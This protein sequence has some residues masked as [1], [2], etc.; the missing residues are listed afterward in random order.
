MQILTVS[1]PA[2]MR[3]A[4]KERALA[5]RRSV[6]E[7]TREAL[8]GALSRAE[9]GEPIQSATAHP[10]LSPL[11]VPHPSALSHCSHVVQ[12]YEGEQFL[13]ENVSEFLASGL[14]KGEPAV[15]IM[16][17]SRLGPLKQ[18]LHLRGIHVAEALEQGRLVL[19]DARQTLARFMVG[20]I[21]DGALVQAVLGGV[22]APLQK[23]FGKIHA[24][25]EMVNILWL[26]GNGESTLQ[27]ER[28]WNKLS[29]VYSFSLLCGYTMGGFETEKH[30]KALEE[31]CSVHGM[32]LPTED[33][34]RFR[35]SED[36]RRGILVLQ[37]KAKILEIQLQERKAIEADLRKQTEMLREE[38]ERRK[39]AEKA[40][41]IREQELTDFVENGP[42]GLHWVAADGT[43]LWA[44][45]AELDLL[46]YSKEEY[47]G[48]HIA[49]FHA[50]DNVI[51]DI[52]ERLTRGEVLQGYEARLRRKDGSVRTVLISSSVYRQGERFVH[53][54]CFTR[55]ISE[56]KAAE[57]ALQ[58]SA[59]DLA[60]S[61]AE[62]AM[63]ASVASHDLKE[64]LRMVR[65]YAQLLD[66]KYG[67]TIDSTGKQYLGYAIDGARRMGDL[68]DDLLAYSLLDS[69]DALEFQ[70]V[71]CNEVLDE[72]RSN[73]AAVVAETNA[74]I[75][76]GELPMVNGV[77]SLLMQLF[78]NLVSNA[79]KFRNG[80]V[81]AVHISAQRLEEEYQFKVSDNGIGIEPKYY[82]RIFLLFQRL[83]E[84]SSYPG[85]GL[86]LAICKKV[87]DRHGGKIWVE[88]EVGKGTTFF[89][90]LA[91]N[92]QEKAVV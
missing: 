55:D 57:I 37:Q 25:G 34:S 3:K 45:R 88:S 41:S 2:E 43:I 33:F 87:V 36:Q 79:I 20:G 31:I 85:T 74:S 42:V 65:T 76:C 51:K 21:P 77:H 23:K 32:T 83:H 44:N 91:I 7:I 39:T 72:V 53:T 92:P 50:D 56:R 69:K 62:L 70:S 63:F 61:N 4:V 12:F 68:I 13:L 75:T 14:L 1:V 86:G 82:E 78:Q 19:L 38:I 73:L 66:K 71:N 60:K 5:E 80:R 48:R 49:E 26:E 64:P 81:P 10:M 22:L 40:L 16:E 52:L 27:L 47:V 89:F 6:S 59:Q 58:K 11:L 8:Q 30:S 84:K 54:R 28:E 9:S 67:N 35:T 46:G 24:Y 17:P 15:A 90:T 29:E 18:H